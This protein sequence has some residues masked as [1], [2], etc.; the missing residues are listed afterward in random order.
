MGVENKSMGLAKIHIKK[1]Y[2]L[3]SETFGNFPK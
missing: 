2:T 1:M 3:L